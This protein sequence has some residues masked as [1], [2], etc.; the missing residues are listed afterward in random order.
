MKYEDVNVSRPRTT[1]MA[2]IAASRILCGANVVSMI[3][4]FWS[5]RQLSFEAMSDPLLS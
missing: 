3:A 2:T 5:L 4:V 1:K